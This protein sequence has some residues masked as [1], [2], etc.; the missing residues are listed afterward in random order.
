MENYLKIFQEELQELL[1]KSQLNMRK[2]TMN[3]I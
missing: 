2:L 3:N 1:I